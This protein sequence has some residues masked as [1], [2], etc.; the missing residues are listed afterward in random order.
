[1][2]SPSRWDIHHTTS[3]A[4][5]VDQVWLALVDLDYWHQ[6]NLWTTLEVSGGVPKEGVKGKLK[7]CYMGDNVKV[8]T[9]DFEFGPVD[10]D[11][12]L[13]TWFGSAGPGDFL[14]HGD[15]T[16]Q[17]EVIDDVTTRLVHKEKFQGL[18][19][20]LGLGLPY[21]QL[22]ENYLKMNEALKNHVESKS[23]G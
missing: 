15:H 11:K 6:W 4:A 23:G 20:R 5:P 18:L 10:E 19:P 22:N 8:E 21:G 17:L 2:L 16:M 13:L 7:A 12:H 1:M 3:I 9:F 14:F